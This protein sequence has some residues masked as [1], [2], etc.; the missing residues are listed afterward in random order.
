MQFH[1]MILI[2]YGGIFNEPEQNGM[3]LFRHPRLLSELLISLIEDYVG[4]SLTAYH[5][6]TQ[7]FIDSGISVLFVCY[8]CLPT[9]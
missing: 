5:T 2:D 1:Y 9:S 6:V 8:A 7:T 3:D 4:F